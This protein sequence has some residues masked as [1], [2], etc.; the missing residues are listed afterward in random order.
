MATYKLHDM[1]RLNSAAERQRRS[2]GKISKA[3]VALDSDM[4]LSHRPEASVHIKSPPTTKSNGSIS[5]I[6]STPI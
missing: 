1:A 5:S 3:F 4:S 2:M 6:P